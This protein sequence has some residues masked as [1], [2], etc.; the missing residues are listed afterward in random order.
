MDDVIRIVLDQRASAMPHMS[1]GLTVQDVFYREVS[2]INEFL[3]SL[4]EHEERLLSSDISPR[5]LIDLVSN[6]TTIFTVSRAN[7]YT[8]LK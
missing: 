7:R 5:E 4:V 2:K 8:H 3:E 6:I 1:T